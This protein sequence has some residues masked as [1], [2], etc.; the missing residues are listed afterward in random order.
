MIMMMMAVHDIVDIVHSRLATR[1]IT[2]TIITRF[3]GKRGAG[4]LLLVPQVGDGREDLALGGDG[5]CCAVAPGWIRMRGVVV[6]M[7][8][9]TLVQNDHSRHE[10]QNQTTHRAVETT[11]GPR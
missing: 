11:R 7:T 9:T 1:T 10:Q 8:T 5:R 4:P 3:I 6:I 2:T